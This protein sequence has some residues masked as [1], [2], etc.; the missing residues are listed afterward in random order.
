[1]YL[2]YVS[3]LPYKMSHVNNLRSPYLVTNNN[4]FSNNAWNKAGWQHINYWLF[5]SPPPPL[6]A[7]KQVSANL[8]P[9]HSAAH[10]T[11]HLRSRFA[12]PNSDL[13]FIETSSP[14]KINHGLVPHN[15]QLGF[16][17][18]APVWP[19]KCNHCQQIHPHP[20]LLKRFPPPK[21]Q[22]CVDVLSLRRDRINQRTAG[23]SGHKDAERFYLFF[24][25]N[26]R[27]IF[28]TT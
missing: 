17:L 9:T 1:M 26:C 28:S 27:R 20:R 7:K 18:N 2:C 13:Q 25:A 15:L 21:K 10:F 19:G 24:C 14:F 22:K 4:T 6:E 11:T 12:K 5:E 3:F 16:S 8:V 23:I